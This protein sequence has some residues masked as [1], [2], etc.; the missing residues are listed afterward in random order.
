MLRIMNLDRTASYL[1]ANLNQVIMLA[2]NLFRLSTE[3]VV[4][5]GVRSSKDSSS[6]GLSSLVRKSGKSTTQREENS[7]GSWSTTLVSK[8][9]IHSSCYFPNK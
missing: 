2:T 9:S 1:T 6:E 4:V 3:E 5:T 7:P 8:K